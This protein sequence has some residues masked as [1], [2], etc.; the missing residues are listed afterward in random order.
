MG[1]FK[2]ISRLG[3]QYGALLSEP[4]LD[5][6]EIAEALYQAELI[7]YGLAMD[8]AGLPTHYCDTL[9]KRIVAAEYRDIILIA[10]IKYCRIQGYQCEVARPEA[11]PAKPSDHYDPNDFG[12]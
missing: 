11:A 2:P 5:S 7:E 3:H 6:R 1:K 10:L 4:K 9:Y 12:V 8:A